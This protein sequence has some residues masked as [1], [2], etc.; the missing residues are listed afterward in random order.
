MIVDPE[1]IQNMNMILHSPTNFQ[2]MILRDRA[3]ISHR[4]LYLTMSDIVTFFDYLTIFF[5]V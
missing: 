4:V 1:D 5:P 3:R 2:F